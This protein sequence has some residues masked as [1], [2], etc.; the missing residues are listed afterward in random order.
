MKIEVAL[1]HGE[2]LVNIVSRE[3]V[4]GTRSILQTLCR[5]GDV[6]DSEALRCVCISKSEVH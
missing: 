2:E 6:E 1:S 3:G 4:Y 5:V